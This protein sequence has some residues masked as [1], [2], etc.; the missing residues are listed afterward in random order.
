MLASGKKRREQVSNEERYHCFVVL[1]QTRETQ[2]FARVGKNFLLE[3]LIACHNYE[4]A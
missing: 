2:P 4:A 1:P 3:L